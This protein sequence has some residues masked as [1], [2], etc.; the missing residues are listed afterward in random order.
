MSPSLTR[1][2]LRAFIVLLLAVLFVQA[3][4]S[5]PISLE[6][7]RGPVFSAATAEVTLP[8]RKD[9]RAEVC[10]IAAPCPDL[11]LLADMVAI[12]ALPSLAFLPGHDWPAHPQTGP[13]LQPP[14]RSLPAP[15][16]P[17]FL[18]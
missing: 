14:Q 6:R 10:T 5:K 11:A 4:P 16:E 7:G 18:T 8:P 17:P 13:P 2:P 12:P 3:I 9:E 1:I 15:R